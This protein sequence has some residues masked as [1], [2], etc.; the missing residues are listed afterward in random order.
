MTL[1]NDP[2]AMYDFDLMVAYFKNP[3][4]AS[5]DGR[6]GEQEC[7]IA[8]F[9]SHPDPDFPIVLRRDVPELFDQEEE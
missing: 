8:N 3:D 2:V 1:R 4:W 6:D 5:G 9:G 7:S